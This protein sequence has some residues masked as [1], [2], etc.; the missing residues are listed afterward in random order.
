M[1]SKNAIEEIM[2]SPHNTWYAI[3]LTEMGI[4][5]SFLNI[6]GIKV[7]CKKVVC[8]NFRKE[9]Q[10]RQRTIF[11]LPWFLKTTKRN[12]EF[13]IVLMPRLWRTVIIFVNL[14]HKIFKSQS[15]KESPQTHR[16]KKYATPFR[17][18][19]LISK[20]EWQSKKMFSVQFIYFD[21]VW[22]EHL[23]LFLASHWGSCFLFLT[24]MT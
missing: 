23:S 17:I 19:K 24:C 9:F 13:G 15:T 16:S 18:P 5:W 22:V 11:N 3:L 8:K 20:G 12:A 21:L 7:V 2:I 4:K 14:C 1:C 6:L 10:E